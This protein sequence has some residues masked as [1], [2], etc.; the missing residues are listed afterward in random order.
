MLHI[1]KILVEMEFRVAFLATLKPENLRFANYLRTL[2]VEPIARLQDVGLTAKN[3]CAFDSVI[4]ARRTNFETYIH[5]IQ[6]YCPSAS[7]IFDTGMLH[8]CPLLLIEGNPNK[9]D[10]SSFRPKRLNPKNDFLTSSMS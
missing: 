4:I 10:R 3:E 5:L 1:L 8:H 7:I 2:G 9:Q 6:H